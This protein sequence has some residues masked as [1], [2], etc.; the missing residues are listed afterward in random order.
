MSTRPNAPYDDRVEGDGSV[1][2]Y[3]GHDASR[4]NTMLDP[5]SID[6]PEEGASG[7]LTENGKFFRAANRY[8]DG[9]DVAHPVKVYEKIR[10]GIWSYN[11]LF[12]LVDAWLIPTAVKLFVWKRDSGRC[13]V[14]GATDELHF[15]HDLP[16][17]LGGTSVKAENVQLMCARHN[18]SKGA[19]IL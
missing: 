16:Y 12:H 2:V 4:S 11:G 19:R 5:K 13:V 1:L 9:T 3:E 17:S 10:D 15:D 6:Q 8:K 14:C 7:R 18:L